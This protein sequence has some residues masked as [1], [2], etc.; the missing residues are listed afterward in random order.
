MLNIKHVDNIIIG[1]IFLELLTNG[2]N[3]RMPQHFYYWKVYQTYY[4][5]NYK[6]HMLE[7]EGPGPRT[8]HK[9]QP[10]STCYV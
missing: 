3:H 5:E 6:D 4:I 7:N 1:F 9:F 8:S 2:E 10:P